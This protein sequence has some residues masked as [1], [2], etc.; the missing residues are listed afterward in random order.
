MSELQIGGGVFVDKVVFKTGSDIKKDSIKANL[1]IYDNS[2]SELCPFCNRNSLKKVKN[3]K[4]K[5][6]ACTLCN[7][8]WD[9]GGQPGKPSPSDMLS[10]ARIRAQDGWSYSGLAYGRYGGG[11]GKINK[12][13]KR[14]KLSKKRKLFRK[15]RLSKKRKSKKKTR[16]RRR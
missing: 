15:R 4:G 5:Y 13:R 16:R 11:G 1:E 10:S 12:S 14:R 3:D 2:A 6:W 8:L 9:N 7:T